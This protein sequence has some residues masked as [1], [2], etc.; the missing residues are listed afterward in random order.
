MKKRF[1]NK[2][3]TAMK[4]VANSLSEDARAQW[5]EMVAAVEALEAEDTEHDITSLNDRL[6]EIEGKYANQEEVANRIQ[7]LRN[8]IT[9][10][11]TAA[12]NVKDKFTP[13]VRMAI[14]N[15][16]LNSRFGVEATQ[17][18]I[19]KVCVENGIEVRKKNSVSGLSFGDII[20]YALQ[21][22]QENN[23]EIFDALYK[24][25]RTKFFYGELDPTNAANIA[26]GWDKSSETSKA[27]QELAVNGKSIATQY[28][29]KLQA[30]AH[31]DLDDAREAGQEGELLR[32]IRDELMRA[33]KGL[34]VRAIFVGDSYNPSGSKVTTFETIGTKTASDLFTTIVNPATATQPTLGDL[35]KTAA[36]VKTARK[37]AVMTSDLKLLLSERIYASGGTPMY[38]TDA[39]L[40]EQIGVER[41][42]AKD[43][44]GD[45][46]GLHAVIF[47][48]D[49]YW[50]KEKNVFDTPFPEYRDNRQGYIYE[51]N[52]GGAIHGLESTAIL[53][54]A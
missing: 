10:Q 53:A 50:V 21:L 9:A 27:E 35:R 26:K 31:E 4:K 51:I 32:D 33:V 47:D 54:E 44:I 37:W 42:I 23:D 40:A 34:A 29:Y 7:A 1:L 15:A 39:E 41:V 20:D 30:L 11:M 46:Q 43:F 16:I 45:V 24:T 5:D 49:E 28:V 13:S 36:A 19:E 6:A 38:L 18:A 17:Q 22:K 14:T 12:K 48:P 25:N 52:M 2:L 8:E 3:V